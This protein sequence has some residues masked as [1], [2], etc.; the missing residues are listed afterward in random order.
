MPKNIEIKAR[1]NNFEAQILLAQEI[2]K[3]RPKTIL[4]EDTFFETSKGLLEPPLGV[5]AFGE[6]SDDHGRLQTQTYH[7]IQC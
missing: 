3:D 6:V 4:Q 7:S 1:A 5:F 2:S